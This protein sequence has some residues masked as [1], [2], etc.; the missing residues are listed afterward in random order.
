M[1]LTITTENINTF[2]E[3]DILQLKHFYNFYD[4]RSYTNLGKTKFKEIVQ[5]MKTITKSDT[6]SF[7]DN[8]FCSDDS[9]QTYAEC[10]YDILTELK[11]KNMI[12]L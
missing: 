11:N 4:E 5:I 2:T 1:K 12:I 10:F 8:C 6:E 7:W 3:S 9:I